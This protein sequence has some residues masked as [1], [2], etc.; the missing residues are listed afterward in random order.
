[1]KIPFLTKKTQ[2]VDGLEVVKIPIESNLLCLR[3]LSPKRLRFELE[4]GLERGSTDNSFLFKINSLEESLPNR[5]ILVHPPGGTYSSAFLPAL[6]KELPPKNSRL[7]VV[8]G[9]V[10]PNRVAFLRELVINYSM[11][12][13][14]SSNPASQLINELWNQTKPG[15]NEINRLPLPEIRIIRKEKILLEFD[16][17]LL[18]LIPAPTPRWPGGLLAFEE[19]LGLL[20]SD[21]FFAAHIFTDQWAETHSS[22]TSEDRRHFYDSLMASMSTQVESIIDRLDNLDISTIAPVHGPA[23]ETSWRSL[24][25]DY[26]RW[27]VG[28]QQ[29]PLKVLLLFASAYGNTAAIADSLARGV[30]RTGVRVESMN[31]EFTSVEELV[32]AVRSADAY[33]IGSPTLGGHAPTPIVSALGTLLSEGDRNKKVGVFG[34]YG[35]SGEALDLLEGK[36]R[37]GGFSFGF[38]PIKIKFSPSS[39]MVKTLEETGTLFARDLIRVHQREKR[40]ASGGLSASR[41]DPTVLALGRIVGSLCVLTA[42]KK[43]G[44]GMLSGAMIASWVS[45][46]SF[47]PPAITV[48]VAK[49]RAIEE[50]LHCDDFFALNVLGQGRVQKLMKQFL[51]VFPPGADRFEGLDIDFSQKG[52]PILKDSIAWLECCVKERMECGDHWLIYAEVIN[53]KLLDQL[54]KTA[55]HHRKSGAN[56]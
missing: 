21:K 36:L 43:Q 45:Q 42:R 24:L 29:L 38:E 7:Q 40:R 28:Q 1:M 15:S 22:T 6:I 4:Y 3:G 34:S 50:L 20:M 16:N 12:E 47:S 49:D 56:Y 48:A 37:D 23:I 5:G 33:L 8:V 46:A 53:G 55:L 14:I 25:N 9:H 44:D 30:S 26:R 32:K 27:G 18:R 2:E 41:S 54:A 31:C 52:Q 39:I 17:Y 35:W 51:Q 13:F 10:N 11:I 19:N